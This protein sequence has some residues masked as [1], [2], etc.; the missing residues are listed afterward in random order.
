MGHVGG[1]MSTR[2]AQVW[3]YTGNGGVSWCAIDTGMVRVAWGGIDWTGIW[4]GFINT[5]VRYWGSNGHGDW[6]LIVVWVCYWTANRL[7]WYGCNIT[8]AKVRVGLRYYTLLPGSGW[9]CYSIN[10]GSGG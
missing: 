6:W 7:G 4:V 2:Q 5:L 9:D 10:T 1:L 3:Y 8:L